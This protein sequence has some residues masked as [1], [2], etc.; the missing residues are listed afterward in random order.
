MHQQQQCS[1]GQ[2]NAVLE[3]EAIAHLA[4]ERAGK[5]EHGCPDHLM[6]AHTSAVSERAQFLPLSTA[7]VAHCC[8]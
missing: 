8:P 1:P 7:C 3:G 2:D 5:Q 6:P 4:E